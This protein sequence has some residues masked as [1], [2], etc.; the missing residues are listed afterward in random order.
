MPNVNFND[1]ALTVLVKPQLM[2]KSVLKNPLKTDMEE[3][4]ASCLF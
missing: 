4:K 1:V 2:S 3:Q